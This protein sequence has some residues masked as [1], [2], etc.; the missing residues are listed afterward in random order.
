MQ[1]SVNLKTLTSALCLVCAVPLLLNPAYSVREENSESTEEDAKLQKTPTKKLKICCKTF[2]IWDNSG[3][4]KKQI[5]NMQQQ[6]FPVKLELTEAGNLKALGKKVDEQNEALQT[7]YA[8]L[9][10]SDLSETEI[11]ELKT[12]EEE[13]KMISI[14]KFKSKFASLAPESFV[15]S[16]EEDGSSDLTKKKIKALRKKR[17]KS[18]HK[19]H[20]GSLSPLNPRSHEHTPKILSNPKNIVRTQVIS[21]L[22]GKGSPVRQSAKGTTNLAIMEQDI[23]E[24]TKLI[25]AIGIVPEFIKKQKENA[26]LRRLLAENGIQVPIDKSEEEENSSQDEKWSEQVSEDHSE[27]EDKKSSQEQSWIPFLSNIVFK[28]LGY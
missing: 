22:K 21:E 23:E 12:L 20:N 2:K 8:E 6:G 26:E 16:V 3:P 18:F 25:E 19:K 9:D 5:G 24:R 14:A 15:Q 17:Q 11:E 28:S 1:T 7:A 4:R 10:V 13:G 27:S